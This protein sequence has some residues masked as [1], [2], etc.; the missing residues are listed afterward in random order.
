M[1]HV[2]V[3]YKMYLPGSHH[4]QPRNTSTE[5][6]LAPSAG[7]DTPY[8]PPFFPQLPYTLPNGTTGLAKLLFWNTTDGITG[9]VLP[10]S[11]FDQNTAANPLT[12]TGWY[13]PIS[14]PAS[15]GDGNG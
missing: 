11:P 5:L 10:P 12:I 3:Y 15:G 8:T 1:P 14:G 6:N 13:W 7:G 2:T 4:R 9:K